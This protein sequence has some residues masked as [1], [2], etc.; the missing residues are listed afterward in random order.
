MSAVSSHVSPLENILDDDDDDSLNDTALHSIQ[1]NNSSSLS[2]TL[3]HQNNNNSNAFHRSNQS[4]PYKQDLSVDDVLE[5][6]RNYVFSRHMVELCIY[7]VMFLT[8][9]LFLPT[10]FK[11]HQ[12]TIP[13]QVVQS[14]G[15][16]VLDFNYNYDYKDEQI[17]NNMLIVL[18]MV[19]PMMIL[20]G[21]ELY[22]RNGYFFHDGSCAF[23]A[24]MTVTLFIT[25]VVK[26]MTG[27]FRPNFYQQCGFSNET[28]A[29]MS[30]D[31]DEDN[32]RMS[33]ISGHSSV[34]FC[35][36]SMLTLIML[37][38]SR[39]YSL[40]NEGRQNTRQH[41]RTG[42]VKLNERRIFHVLMYSPIMLAVYI[43]NTRIVDYY[44]HESDV[45]GGALLGALVAILGYHMWYPSVR[46]RNSGI[47]R[48]L[49]PSNRS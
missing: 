11:V 33:F 8:I 9:G 46:S 42:T 13:Y 49:L 16:V 23:I 45:I 2:S 32:V 36:L 6:G 1:D 25:G 37:G 5:S 47:P 18:T 31:Y 15:D 38:A 30:Q 35:G 24:S 26:R 28:L 14:T 27:I 22:N 7:L 29:C 20:L 44:H 48:R 40:D 3:P 43:G 4:V 10:V 21:M 34:A 12:R 19:L 41:N 17:D 39:V